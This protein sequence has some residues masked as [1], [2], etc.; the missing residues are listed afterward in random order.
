MG[1]YLRNGDCRIKVSPNKEG[2]K[3]TIKSFLIKLCEGTKSRFSKKT[4]ETNKNDWLENKSKMERIKKIKRSSSD[5][6]IL[7]DT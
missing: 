5:K 7:K 3:H 1:Y 2:K 4:K 6:R